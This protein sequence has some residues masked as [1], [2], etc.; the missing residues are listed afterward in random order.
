MARPSPGA[1]VIFASVELFGLHELLEQARELLRSHADAGLSLTRDLDP[2]RRPSA[3]SV[4]TPPRP[5]TAP[6]SVKLAGN[7]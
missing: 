4:A 2:S 6:F 5:S 3:R 7:C 1:A